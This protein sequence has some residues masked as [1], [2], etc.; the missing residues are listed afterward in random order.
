MKLALPIFCAVL[1]FL[2]AADKDVTKDG[3]ACVTLYVYGDN[4]CTGPPLRE[5]T[6]PT[7]SETGSS[8]CK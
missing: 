8:C 4:K 5:I 2:S 6:F 7:M 3:D 1:P